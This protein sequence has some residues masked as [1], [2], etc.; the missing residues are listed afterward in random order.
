MKKAT[1]VRDHP[2]LPL[3]TD[4]AW[5]IGEC[6]TLCLCVISGA[7]SLYCRMHTAA[8]TV[9]SLYCRMH[10]AAYAVSEA[11]RFEQSNSEIR[12]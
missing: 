10:T 12:C 3:C 2:E 7:S 6:T 9:S 11:S 8:F 1:S 5:A 4:V